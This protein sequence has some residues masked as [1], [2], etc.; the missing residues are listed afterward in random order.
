MGGDFDGD[1]FGDIA[2]STEGGEL[3]LFTSDGGNAWSRT[4][5]M[6][7]VDVI[8]LSK[9]D[10]NS[11]GIEDLVSILPD[12]LGWHESRPALPPLPRVFIHAMDTPWF[13]YADV[14]NDGDFDFMVTRNAQSTVEWMENEGGGSLLSRLSTRASAFH[15]H[16]SWMQISTATLT[17]WSFA[18]AFSPRSSSSQVTAPAP[19]A[20]KQVAP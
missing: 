7:G 4:V 20:G 8:T 10:L 13:D 14:D 18:L 1:G 5:L 15:E 16:P 17:L 9:C 3:L 19:S 2:V 11:D 6:T 12:G